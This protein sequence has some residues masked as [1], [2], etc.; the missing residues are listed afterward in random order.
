VPKY[1]AVASAN[2]VKMHIYAGLSKL[3]AERGSVLANTYAKLTTEA[4]ERDKELEHYYNTRLSGGKWQGM[5]SSAHVGYVHWDAEGWKYPAVHT[6]IPGQDAQ[7]IVDVEGTEQGY[8]TGTASL[9]VFTN[10]HQETYEI[11][12]SNGGAAEF[13]RPLP[14]I[15]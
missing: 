5:M 11:T 4:I 6:I 3:Y 2:V 12:V 10:L 14:F 13:I 7:M 9:P 1:P 15:R 8:V